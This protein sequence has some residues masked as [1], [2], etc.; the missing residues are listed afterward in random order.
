M[1]CRDCTHFQRRL[2]EQGECRRWPPRVDFFFE[3]GATLRQERP[4]NPHDPA[5]GRWPIVA[6]E[7]WCGEYLPTSTARLLRDSE[8]AAQPP[9]L[10]TLVNIIAG[11]DQMSTDAAERIAAKI[12]EKYPCE[13]RAR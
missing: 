10:Q 5:V 2:T 9:D 3:I 11:T 7:S 1:P 8:Q 6:N 12:M 4:G 13:I